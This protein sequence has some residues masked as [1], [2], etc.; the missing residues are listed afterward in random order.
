[1]QI[2]VCGITEQKNL[3]DLDALGVDMVGLNFYPKSS[4][5]LDTSLDL[6][7][8]KAQK[9]GVFVNATKEF[10]RSKCEEFHL[11]AIQLHG[12]ESEDFC[13][14]FDSHIRVI[15]VFRVHDDFDMDMANDWNHASM[16]LFDTRTSAFGGSGKKF[17]WHKLDEYRGDFQFLLSGGIG[18]EDSIS[19]AA[20]EHP[21][22]AG[23]DINSRFEIKPG[24]KDTN[25]VNRFIPDLK[26][27]K[28]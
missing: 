8:I 16:L 7:N 21:K 9:V 22:F 4:R 28:G 10:I 15:K 3:S 25:L 14:Q 2:K 5:F 27:K 20:F 1:M 17:N 13:S 18:P 6:I 11:D 26:V 24:L 19:I 23:V 12:D